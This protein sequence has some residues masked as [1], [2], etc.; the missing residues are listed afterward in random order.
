MEHETVEPTGANEHR[1]AD[2][3]GCAPHT[4]RDVRETAATIE[5]L[6]APTPIAD[7]PE[8]APTPEPTPEALVPRQTLKIVVTL[9]P[10]D[11]REYRALLAVAA[12]GCDPVLRSATVDGLPAALDRVPA[13]LAEAEAQWQARPR[14]PAVAAPPV[15]RAAGGRRRPR[16]SGDTSPPNEPDQRGTTTESPGD[17]AAPATPTGPVAPRKRAAGDQLT[18]FG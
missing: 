12:D 15:G 5:P 6:A 10:R 3:C 13:L 7:E 8:P 2:A 18:L 9:Q 14:N 16:D 17:V 1:P 11:D 4:P